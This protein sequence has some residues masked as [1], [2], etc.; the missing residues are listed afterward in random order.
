MELKGKF[1]IT[2]DTICDGMQCQFDDEEKK[3]PTLYDSEADANFEI[4]CDAMAGLEGTDDDYFHDNNIDK[5]KVLAEMEA[6]KLEGDN[7]KMRDY[8]QSTTGANY[9]GE[10][11]E[12]A[13]E[14][15][16]GR[17]AIFTGNGLVIEGN[18][19]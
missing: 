15:V 10:S 17:K 5:E 8:L 1:V 19:L 3:I 12:P 11:V 13:D 18:K 16:L 9:Y 14:F 7:D 2:Y 4:F 6:L